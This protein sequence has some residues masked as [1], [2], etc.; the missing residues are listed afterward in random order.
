MAFTLKKHCI[1]E[2]SDF[3]SHSDRFYSQTKH[4]Q[5]IRFYSVIKVRI[6]AVL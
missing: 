2:I 3:K 5:I 1:K 6:I 4:P